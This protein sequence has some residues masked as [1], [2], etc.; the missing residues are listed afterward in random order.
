MTSV[1]DILDFLD[2]K[3]PLDTQ[4][5]FD[6]AGFL[7]GDAAAEVTRVLV[8]LDITDGVVAEA[9][10]FGAELIVS[11][12]PVCFTP[13]KSVTTDDLTGRKFAAMLKGGI[14]A[15]CMH[16]NLDAAPGGVNDA[17]CAA[18][19]AENLG[20]LAPEHDTMSRLCRFAEPMEYAD[21]LAHVKSALGAN[22]IRC[23]G[24]EKRVQL[25]GVCGGA[26]ADFIPDAAARGCDAYITAD[27]K[28]HQFLWAGE[29]GIALVDAGH[30]STENVVVPVLAGWLRERFP[31][32]EVKTA[33]SYKQPER[34]Y[35]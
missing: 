3:A 12:H 10:D 17:L 14:S 16:T 27:V 9:A 11:H 33:A 30:F 25:F 32:L 28:H 26:G 24:P 29:L 7:C 13:M 2:D 20:L 5:D 34:F 23:A 35:V 8:A 15:I 22:G 31:A 1:K 4:L 6:N 18:L 19:G 21:F